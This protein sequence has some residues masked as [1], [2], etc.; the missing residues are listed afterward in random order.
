MHEQ[1]QS[2]TAANCKTRQLI[3]L[4]LRCDYN[5]LL[6]FSQLAKL[7]SGVVGYKAHHVNKAGLSHFSQQAL[8]HVVSEWMSL[9]F[10]LIFFFCLDS[11]YIP[12][13][14]PSA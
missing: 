9:N 12:S 5:K 10:N 14:S 4:H 6:V 2:N 3:Y 7:T 8:A 11:K 13:N 1:P